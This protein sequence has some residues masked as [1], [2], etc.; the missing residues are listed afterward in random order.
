MFDRDKW[1]EILATIRQNKWRTLATAFG[2]FWGIL[3]LVLLLG[4]GQGMQNGVVSSMILDATNSIW[5]FSSRTSLPYNG[6]P[7]G[8]RIEFTEEDL[9]YIGD[10]VQGVEYIAPE[11]WLMGNFNIV[12]GARSSPFMVLGA[13]K[14]Y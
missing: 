12:R 13:G 10:N 6:L 3:M 4:A 11:N 9:Q 1:Q 14:D 2:V 8:R 5:F 7:P